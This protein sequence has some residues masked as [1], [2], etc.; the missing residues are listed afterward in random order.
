M[1]ATNVIVEFVEKG[2]TFSSKAGKKLIAKANP[3]VIK[4][5][6]KKPEVVRA[7]VSGINRNTDVS[8]R[9]KVLSA[10]SGS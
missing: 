7:L 4:D 9:R 10:L 5:A 3:S 8:F 2:G 1:D 6:A